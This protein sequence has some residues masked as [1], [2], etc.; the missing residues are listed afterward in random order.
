M[1]SSTQPTILLFL[2]SRPLITF[3]SFH[4]FVIHV[5]V[6]KLYFNNHDM[7][8]IR[9]MTGSLSGAWGLGDAISNYTPV[10]SKRSDSA[11]VVFEQ[12]GIITSGAFTKDEAGQL[13]DIVAKIGINSTSETSG[14]ER[15]ENAALTVG[16][17][18]SLD[19]IKAGGEGIWIMITRARRVIT[20]CM[21]T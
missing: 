4:L 7:N 5:V 6:A 19:A 18:T 10:N 20:K 3:L 14:A 2:D 11:D 12:G 9:L 21:Q 1:R 8:L 15:L 16:T 13:L 17:G